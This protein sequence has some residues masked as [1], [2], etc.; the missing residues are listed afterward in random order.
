M[1][2]I[3]YGFLFF[4]L[5]IIPKGYAQ[6]KDD[7]YYAQPANTGLYLGFIYVSTENFVLVGLQE[8]FLFNHQKLIVDTLRLSYPEATSFLDNVYHVSMLDNGLLSV[9][10]L[11]R[12]ILV[13]ILK[14]QF[15]LITDYNTKDLIKQLGKY[16]LFIQFKSG[17]LAR[18]TKGK[19][20]SHYFFAKH[21]GLT[22]FTKVTTNLTP[23]KPD[24]TQYKGSEILGFSKYQSYGDNIFI[25]N[26]KQNTLI[27]Y[28]TVTG[29]R[30]EV[31]LPPVEAGKQVH[32]FY[33]DQFT[34]DCYLIKIS[35]NNA[36]TVSLMEEADHS[37]QEI[38]GTS[39]IIRG[40][41]NRKF[42]VSGTF[43]DAIA[44]YLI[45]VQGQN[46]PVKF[47]EN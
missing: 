12:T 28:N 37:F 39:Y 17:I 30:T 5:L 2:F 16:D 4:Y 24:V 35:D 36:N 45:P 44:H 1:K 41:Y 21:D 8:L 29:E 25:F 23:D 31:I 6:E 3:R 42:Y 20:K 26:R 34:G 7:L 40:V 9:S 33:V 32:E 22:P 46:P 18:S 14:D 47:I 10:T 38:V 27:K 15:K 13:S 11:R 19:V 43:D